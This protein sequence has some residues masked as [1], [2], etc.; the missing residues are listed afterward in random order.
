[1]ETVAVKGLWKREVNES[2]RSRLM[3]D[4]VANH[5]V[6]C[7]SKCPYCKNVKGCKYPIKT[8]TCNICGKRFNLEKIGVIATFSSLGEMQVALRTINW[9]GDEEPK[10]DQLVEMEGGKRNGQNK[11]RIGKDH[12]RTSILKRLEMISSR[13]RLIDELKSLGFEPGDIEETLEELISKGLVYSPRYGT[14]K[15]V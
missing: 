9:K 15:L 1:M 5:T 8:T 13:D 11:E 12:L 2:A 10:I 6:Y 7:I 14:L 3:S 4:V